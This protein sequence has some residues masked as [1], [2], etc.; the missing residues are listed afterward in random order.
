MAK[1]KKILSIIVIAVFSMT[2][3]VGCSLFVLN[4]DR[5]REQQVMTVGSEVVMLGEV[6]DFFNA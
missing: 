1:F 6:I 5:Y 2:F 4:E 3:L